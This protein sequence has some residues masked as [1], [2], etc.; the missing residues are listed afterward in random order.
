MT[1]K[2]ERKNFRRRIC[3][4]QIAMTTV[5][6]IDWSNKVTASNK[7]N[8][9]YNRKLS[10]PQAAN[11][12]TH[13][14]GDQ[15]DNRT[16]ARRDVEADSRADQSAGVDGVKQGAVTVSAGHRTGRAPSATAESAAAARR[17]P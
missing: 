7:I 12:F 3:R 16:V 9:K 6:L 2:L 8:N 17:P 5:Q 10:L 15:T 1:Q 14:R 4:K 13:H 11:R